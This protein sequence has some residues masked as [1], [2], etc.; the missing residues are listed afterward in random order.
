LRPEKGFIPERDSV[1]G[2]RLCQWKKS[3]SIRS[4]AA[5][6][7]CAADLIALPAHAADPNELQQIREQINQLKESYEARLQALEQRLQAMQQAG[8]TSAAAASAPPAPGAAPVVSPA[9]ASA[10]NPAISLILNGSYASLSQD[11]ANYRLQ[12]FMPS[13]GDVG[14]GSRGFQLGE[15]ELSLSASIDPTF[16]G[17]LTFSLTGDN[18]VSVEE[19]VF[20]RQGLFNGA[21]LK[22]GRFLSSV[23]YLN[24]QHA[25]AWDFVDAPLVY[26]AF[27]GGPSKT[28]GL[29]LRWLAPTD[30]FLELGAEL[31]AGRSF[32]GSDTG[33]NG[34]G[35]VSLFAHL[36]DDL[37]DSASW[38]IGLS[39]V[40]NKA[41][42]RAYN[43]SS[44]T[45]APVTN[46]FTG[47]SRTWIVDGIYKW[48][49]NGN[50]TQTNFKLQ[51]EYFQRVEDGTLNYDTAPGG[52]AIPG[53]Y[54]A[55][56]SG[57]YMQAVYQFMPMW[58]VGVRYDK[59]NSGVPEIG[60]V[61]SSLLSA[62][63][64]PVLQSAS[65]SRTSL[66]VDYSLSEFSRF[67]LQLSGDQSR[68]GI[69][70]NQIY[71]QYIMSLG[72]HGAH[73]F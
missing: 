48:A 56:Q 26:Q 34:L 17:H 30:R 23:G 43:D 12:G 44:S 19:A 31:G 63:D 70:D 41:D 55:T 33:R 68:P 53:S 72:T 49:P 39:Y 22:V 73:S 2:V 25:H 42:D 5:I 60:Q 21:S 46:T 67:R 58:R 24:S 47:T 6:A 50:A 7:L 29:Q 52:A 20:E 18:Q 62:A 57:W 14:P 65:P 71:L 38:R 8:A 4:I 37:G 9:S 59:L 32:P 3:M 45:G 69:T 40:Q 11:P 61:G 16:S 51:G 27:L 13:G 28:D 64:F 35:T 66:M 15:S 10:F 1:S 54:R 36:G